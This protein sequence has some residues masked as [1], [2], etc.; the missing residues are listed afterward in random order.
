LSSLWSSSSSSSL[1][2]PER[3]W[4]PVSLYCMYTGKEWQ[5]MK[6]D[7]HKLSY[8]TPASENPRKNN[9]TRTLTL[10]FS[11]QPWTLFWPWFR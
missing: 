9:T 1:S 10:Q 2:F 11:L 3:I 8:V 7:A 4:G 6:Q 5:Q